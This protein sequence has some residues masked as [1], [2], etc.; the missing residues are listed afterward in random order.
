MNI[1][2]AKLLSFLS[3]AANGGAE[4]PS[5]ILEEFGDLAK[6]ALQKHFTKQDILDEGFR[7]RMSN[8]G[9]PLCQLQMQARG[10]EEE[11]NDYSFKMRM[12]IGDIL[13][14]VLITLIKASDIEVKNIHKKVEL[15]DKDIDVKGEFD[16]ELSDGIYDIKTV[17]PYAFD[18]KFSVDNAFESIKSSDTFGYVSQGYGYGVAAGRP[19]KGWIALNKSTG[20]IAFAEAPDDKKQKKEV[21]DAIK[22]THRTIHNGEP[23]KRCFTDVEETYYSKPTGNRILGFECSYCPYKFSCW[24]NLEYR[25][26]LPSKGKNPKW[27]WYTTISDEWRNTAD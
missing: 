4:M 21:V 3:K 17:S 23:F 7:L 6:K 12:I 10:E 13:E 24:E 16:I 9:K 25:R 19:F 20:Q 5:Q 2:Q 1:H 27:T 11:P 26:Q 8:I 22:K 14:A 18:H 15:Q